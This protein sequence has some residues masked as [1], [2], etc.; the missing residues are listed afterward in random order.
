VPTVTVLLN[1]LGARFPASSALNTGAMRLLLEYVYALTAMW[2]A[3]ALFS[4][5]L[6]VKWVNRFFTV[7]TLTHYYRR[8]HEPGT[9]LKDLGKKIE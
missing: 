6:R 3:Y 5:L 4:L 9:S 2:V 7:T 1:W 8:Y